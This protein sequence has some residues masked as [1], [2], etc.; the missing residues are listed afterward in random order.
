MTRMHFCEVENNSGLIDIPMARIAAA[1]RVTIEPC[2]EAV[3]VAAAE[4]VRAEAARTAGARVCGCPP[5]GLFVRPLPVLPPLPQLGA[6]K[7]AEWWGGTI[8]HYRQEW[9]LRELLLVDLIDPSWWETHERSKRLRDHWLD[10]DVL[11]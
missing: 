7:P 2:G 8:E 4:A 10:M 5:G 11:G 6:V 3:A 9:R 1:R